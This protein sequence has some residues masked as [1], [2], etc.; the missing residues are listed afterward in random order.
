VDWNADPDWDWHSAAED[1]PEQ[2]QT[3]W[4]DAVARSRC[5]VTEALADGGLE[6]DEWKGWSHETRHL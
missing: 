3:L 4:Q 2:L 6:R 5:L 1:S